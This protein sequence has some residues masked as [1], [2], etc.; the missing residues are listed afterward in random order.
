MMREYA[1]FLD[2]KRRIVSASGFDVKDSDLHPRPFPFQRAIIRWGLRRGRAAIFAGTGLGKTDM[3]LEWARFVVAETGLPV[4]ILAPLGV[5]RQTVE[6]AKFLALNVNLCR[7]DADV[8]PSLNITNYDR[9]ERFDFE[10][11]GGVVL[12]ESSIIKSFT[13][14]TKTALI[15]RCARMRFR[16]ACTA[17]PAPNDVMELGNHSEF[18][19]VLPRLEMLATYFT[20]DGGDTQKW[21]L[22]GHAQREFWR[23]V[24]SW[25]VMLQKPSDLGFEDTG[26]DLP[27]LIMR[28][29][30][31][32][33]TK[34]SDGMLFAMPAQ[35]LMDRRRVRSASVSTRSARTAEIIGTHPGPWLA[36][37]DLNAEADAISA[38]VPH[39]VE[40][41][42]SDDRDVKEQRLLDFAHGR[43]PALVSK[44]RI[45]G[46]GLNFQVCS[47]QV[48]A[49][50]S[51]SWESLYQAIRRSWRFG[52]KNDVECHL[53]LTEPERPVLDNLKR[54]EREAEAMRAAM[55]AEAMLA[56]KETNDLGPL[57]YSAPSVE[58]PLW[59]QTAS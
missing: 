27:R 17:T 25:A 56:F 2:G 23:W 13:G 34:A 55:V 54:K 51:D 24:S 37:C 31:I 18:L 9:L 47:H 7:E 5:A 45:C 35:G 29:H 10:R 49:G 38:I 15:E 16:L 12:D 3:Q 43:I 57:V 53:V 6:E 42:G 46:F 48:F 41:R 26:Y 59:L 22:K 36:W 28:E 1:A 39:A 30:V 21:R 32:E 14:A 50:I 33:A 4:L 58:V 19:G 44:V 8:R 20:H 11:F 52:Q 40:I